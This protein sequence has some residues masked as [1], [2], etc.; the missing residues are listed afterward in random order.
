MSKRTTQKSE[1]TRARILNAALATFRERGFERATMREIAEAADVATGAAYYYFD[2]KESLVMAFYER[3]QQEMQTDLEA[4]LARCR[5]LE[6]R[7]RVIITEKFDYF[8]PN[9]K[10]LGALSAHADPEHPLSPFSNETKPIRD[11]DMAFFEAA[12]RDSGVKL[13]KDIQPYLPRLLWLYQM[14][15][16]LFWVYDRSPQQRRTHALFEQ[17]LK[18]LLLTLRLASIPLLRPMHRL[19]A[20]LLRTVYEEA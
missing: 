9:R 10:L 14:G 12:A 15:L 7:L 17:T 19:A 18:M 6:S 5:T 16:I 20:E 1:E 4:A 8:G 3:A 11:A 2:S 13:P